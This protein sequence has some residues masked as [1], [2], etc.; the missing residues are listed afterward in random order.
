M[1]VAKT[2][3]VMGCAAALAP[4]LTGQTVRISG[5]VKDGNGTLLDGAQ[6]TVRDPQGRVLDKTVSNKQGDYQSKGA[7]GVVSIACEVLADSATYPDV[8][9]LTILSN[10]AKMDFTFYQ[11]TTARSYWK[12]VASTVNAKASSA[13]DANG[14]EVIDIRVA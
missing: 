3:L 12:A 4:C 8:E 14:G 6:I 11:V 10:A 1:R 7:R 9:Q 2:A 13:P 5:T